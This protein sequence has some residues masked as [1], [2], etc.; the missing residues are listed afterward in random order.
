MYSLLKTVDFYKLHVGCVIECKRYN[1]VGL[2][3]FYNDYRFVK[4]CN[5]QNS[6]QQIFNHCKSTV[7]HCN[8]CTTDS[9]FVNAE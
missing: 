6:M 5:I 3:Y 4:V 2:Q 9:S 8:Q 7:D 1:F